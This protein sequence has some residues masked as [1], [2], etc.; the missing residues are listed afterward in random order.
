MRLGRDSAATPRPVGH[1]SVLLGYRT[2]RLQLMYSGNIVNIFANGHHCYRQLF[3][4]F[5]VTMRLILW[6]GIALLCSGLGTIVWALNEFENNH[7]IVID[8]NGHERLQFR[9]RH[10]TSS[11]YWARVEWQDKNGNCV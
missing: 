1:Y 6:A 8:P 4:E 10:W 9:T 5:G 2:V 3:D 7:N 11:H